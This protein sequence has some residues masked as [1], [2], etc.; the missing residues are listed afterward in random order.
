MKANE[1]STPKGKSAEHT[2]TNTSK[3]HH[4][5]DTSCE[6]KKGSGCGTKK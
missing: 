5:S 4:S 2:T 3:T 1:K 6:N